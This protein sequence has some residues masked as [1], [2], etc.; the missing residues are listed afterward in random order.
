MI[1]HKVDCDRTD[2]RSGLFWGSIPKSLEKVR[3]GESSFW[4]SDRV[5]RA[6][7]LILLFDDDL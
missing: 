3:A 4:R 2:V 1:D 6:W 7:L 5:Q